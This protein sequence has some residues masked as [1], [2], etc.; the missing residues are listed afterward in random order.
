MTISNCQAT[1]STENLNNKQ[2]WV[3]ESKLPQLLK[4][5]FLFWIKKMYFS[6]LGVFCY[7]CKRSIST[8][9]ISLGKRT[10]ANST[11]EISSL[12]YKWRWN[13]PVRNILP[14][15]SLLLRYF[16]NFEQVFHIKHSWHFVWRKCPM[17]IVVTEEKYHV[18]LGFSLTLNKIF[19][20]S[21]RG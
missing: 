20:F 21:F 17:S 16:V 8:I 19:M 10:F 4:N 7:W 13:F 14:L 18:F 11:C 3:L 2:L 15:R 12:L 1:F 9:I 5:I 6:F